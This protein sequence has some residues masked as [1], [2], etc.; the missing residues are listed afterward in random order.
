MPQKPELFVINYGK[1]L[2]ILVGLIFLSFVMK[3]FTKQTVLKEMDKKV[4]TRFYCIQI[5]YIKN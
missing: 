3:K 4:S 2:Y 1:P 5:Y